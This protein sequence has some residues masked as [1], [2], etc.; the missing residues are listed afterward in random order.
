MTTD[1]LPP[2]SAT[3]YGRLAAAMVSVFVAPRCPACRQPP[4]ACRCS[5]YCDECECQTNHTGSDHRAAEASR[6]CPECGAPY[7]SLREVDMLP[8]GRV[9]S[10]LCAVCFE[11]AE[12]PNDRLTAD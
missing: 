8:G 9:E 11:E 10:P 2:L 6:L 12:R 5:R 7:G 3:E 4:S 1:D